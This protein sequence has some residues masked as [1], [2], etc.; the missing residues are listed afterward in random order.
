MTFS[1]EFNRLIDRLAQGRAAV[2]GPSG[3]CGLLLV[4][5]GGLGDTMLFSLVLRRFR[6]LVGPDEPV[7]LVVRQESAA[8]GFLFPPEV[9]LIPVNYRKFL[10]QPLYRHRTFRALA[11][12]GFRVAVST[13]H[14]R[15]PTVDDV[16]ILASG[17]DQRLGME[18]RGWPKHDAQLANNRAW[19]SRLVPVAPG[20]AH[21]M[22]RW[23][24]LANA[25]TGRADPPP[26]VRFDAARLP[27]PAPLEAPS[28][29]L[30]PFS[31][32]AERGPGADLFEAV[33]GALPPGLDVVLSAAPGDLDRRPAFRRL[34]DHAAVRLDTSSL[35]DKAA[36]LRAARLVVTVDTSILH[37]AAG[38]GAPTLCLAS[39]AHVI[40]S[41]PYDPR[42]TP[43]NVTFLYH[44][45]PCRGCLGNC[46]LP[47]EDGVYPCV[48][49][50]DVGDVLAHVK[51]VLADFEAPAQTEEAR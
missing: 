7:S 47:P 44:D 4:S 35:A 32:V 21:R 50:L 49:R 13:D 2:A 39:A 6:A 19:Y 29:V 37:L 27:P 26:V 28:V 24:D 23:V 40:D 12:R 17:A 48:A 3:R 31:A 41:V 11:D 9:E 20:M 42:M 34:L 14:L 18:P 38:V 8:A 45:M 1:S 36:L 30:H 33:I 46:V 25:L 15:L 22:V 51:T 5:S 16:F 43:A 10:R